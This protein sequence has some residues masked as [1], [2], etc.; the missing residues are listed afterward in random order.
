MTEPLDDRIRKSLAALMAAAPEPRS[1]SGDL[2]LG[3][4]AGARRRGPAWIAAPAAAVVA[5]LAIGLPM[6]LLRQGPDRT[7]D[8]TVPTSAGP[9][10]QTTDPGTATTPPSA[11]TTTATSLVEAEYEAAFILYPTLL[12]EGWEVCWEVDIGVHPAVPNVSRFCPPGTEDRWVQVAVMDAAVAGMSRGDPIPDAHN[13]MWLPQ[14]GETLAVGVPVGIN[15]ALVV[16]ARGL[17]PASLLAVVESIPIVGDRQALYG[18]YELPL[19][20]ALAELSDADLGQLVSDLMDAPRIGERR[21]FEATVYG[22]SMRLFISEND[23][24]LALPDMARTMPRPRL[25]SVEGRP[26][27]VGES[28]YRGR[29]Y[30]M[31]DQ[32]GLFFRF[33]GPGTAED[34]IA[35]ASLIMRQVED[36]G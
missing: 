26:V 29:S 28:E 1:L 12:P 15:V 25:V 2:T 31:W 9:V 34:V 35:I 36:L 33:E 14:T 7:A 19:P 16:T 13:A 23:M 32:R 3:K 10:T 27:V 17:D 8:S 22:A 24:Y 18:P 30:A 21:Q 5:V 4:P 11:S 6:L 20:V